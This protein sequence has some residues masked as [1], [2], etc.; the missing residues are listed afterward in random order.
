MKQGLALFQ[1][2]MQAIKI[3]YLKIDWDTGDFLLNAWLYPAFHLVQRDQR[4]LHINFM[5]LQTIALRLQTRLGALALAVLRV[6]IN[7]KTK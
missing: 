2:M 6:F 7:S 4:Q 5:G 3:Q 1:H